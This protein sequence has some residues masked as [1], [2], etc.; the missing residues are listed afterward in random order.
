MGVS[1]PV[2][3]I[4]KPGLNTFLENIGIFETLLGIW[5]SLSL[6]WALLK[7]FLSCLKPSFNKYEAGLYIFKPG[8]T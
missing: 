1:E 8:F 7:S 4:L 5:I 6:A 2:L 3:I